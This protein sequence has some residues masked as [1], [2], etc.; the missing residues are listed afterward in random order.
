MDLVLQFVAEKA[1]HRMIVENILWVTETLIDVGAKGATRPAV[2]E[3]LN[4]WD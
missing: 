2:G 1:V 4:G 3:S